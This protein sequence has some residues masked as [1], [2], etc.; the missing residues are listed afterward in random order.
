MSVNKAIIVGYAGKD[1]E[2]R[3]MTNGDPVANVS[4]A[5][6]EK[7]KDKNTGEQKEATEWHRITIYGKLAEIAGEYVKKGTL[8]YF[9]GKIKTRKWTDTNGV[10]KYTTEI[11]AESMRLLGGKQESQ[12]P[13]QRPASGG[14]RAPAPT[15]VADLDDDIPFNRLP[16]SYAI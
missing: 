5:T 13:A 11:H 1:T 2:V 16:N 4:V 10:E 12:Q 6:T 9:E 3:Y 15:S 8:A 14:N 7:W